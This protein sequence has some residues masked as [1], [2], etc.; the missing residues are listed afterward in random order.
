MISFSISFFT[1][2]ACLQAAAATLDA[3]AA[4]RLISDR[5]R[6]QKAPHGPGLK[7]W[8]WKSDGSVCLRIEGKTGKCADTE[9]WKLNGD[10]LC[11]ELEWGGASMNIKSA[12]FRI[13]DKGKGRYEALQ[14]NGLSLYEFP[15]VK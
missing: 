8:S 9:H 1:L 10:R 6:Q 7:Y 5:M 3:K 2:R 12:C 11:Y 4:K 15:V 14:D 13:S